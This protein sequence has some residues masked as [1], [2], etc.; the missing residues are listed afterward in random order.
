MVVLTTKQKEMRI[1][2]IE[3]GNRVSLIFAWYDLWIGAYYDRK[4]RTLYILPIPTVG[5]KI[6]FGA[7]DMKALNKVINGKTD[8]NNRNR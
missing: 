2:H 8:R 7:K 4:K 6:Q 3:I 5:I 1:G